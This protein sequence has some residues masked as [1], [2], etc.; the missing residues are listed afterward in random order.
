MRA[1]RRGAL[2]IPILFAILAGIAAT[3]AAQAAPE[4]W[5]WNYNVVLGRRNVSEKDWD[6]FHDYGEMGIEASWGKA[7]EP[8]LFATDFYASQ[9]IKRIGLATVESK[10]FEL[11]LG[12]RKIWT[13]KKR[14]NPYF[15]AGFTLASADAESPTSS[16]LNSDSDLTEGMWAGAGIFFRAG[17]NFNFGVVAR[18][19]VMREYRIFGINRDANSTHIGFVIGWGAER[20]GEK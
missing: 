16:G 1:T 7:D 4:D 2:S 20:S 14:W 15:G 5:D 12:L 3:T 9:D 13:F 11:D 8:L 6:P 17:T 10:S 19:T 18:A